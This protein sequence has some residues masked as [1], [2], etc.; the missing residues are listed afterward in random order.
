MI[1]LVAGEAPSQS[2]DCRLIDGIAST[3][4]E[5]GTGIFPAFPDTVHDRSDGLGSDC[6]GDALTNAKMRKF[7]RICTSP[8]LTLPPF[9]HMPISAAKQAIRNESALDTGGI[10]RRVL[11]NAYRAATRPEYDTDELS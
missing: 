9:R 1:L 8:S 10:K 7:Y 4:W 5:R 3:Q 11:S 2:A 6:L